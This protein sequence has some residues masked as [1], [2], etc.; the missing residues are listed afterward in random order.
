MG[1]V[2][3][4]ATTVTCLS[5]GSRAAKSAQLSGKWQAHPSEGEPGFGTN[6]LIKISAR[7]Q[8]T[9]YELIV[10]RGP[11]C[12]TERSTVNLVAQQCI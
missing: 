12:G 3:R 8:V 10:A 7:V 9:G 2:V 4:G 11:G 1:Y 6:K 5:W